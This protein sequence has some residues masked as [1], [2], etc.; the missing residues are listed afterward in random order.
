MEINEKT[1]KPLGHLKFD[2]KIGIVLVPTDKFQ[3]NLERLRKQSDVIKILPLYNNTIRNEARAAFKKH[4][5][6]GYRYKIIDN[7]DLL[8]Q[9]TTKDRK[10]RFHFNQ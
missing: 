3:E 9:I 4:Y 1:Y 7:N 5:K 2:E 6:S 8:V 10:N